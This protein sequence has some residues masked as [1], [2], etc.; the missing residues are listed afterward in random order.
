MSKDD[1]FFAVDFSECCS[2]EVMFLLSLSV[3]KTLTLICPSNIQQIRV[4]FL[5]MIPLPIID[6]S[7]LDPTVY[8]YVYVLLDIMYVCLFFVFACQPTSLGFIPSSNFLQILHLTLLVTLK[9][10]L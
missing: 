4:H 1:S 9:S 2:K 6:L 5:L 10:I 8:V 7:G 3:Y